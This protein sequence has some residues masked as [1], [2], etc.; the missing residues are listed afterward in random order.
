MSQF[1]DHAYDTSSDIDKIM[2]LDKKRKIFH[3][4]DIPDVTGPIQS[5]DD[6]DARIDAMDDFLYRHTTVVYNNKAVTPE[7]RDEIKIKDAME[8]GGFNVRMLMDTRTDEERQRDK[9]KERDKK[10]EEELLRRLQEIDARKKARKKG[11]DI[12]EVDVKKSEKEEAAEKK[13]KKKEKKKAKKEK[14]A[15]EAMDNITKDDEFDTAKEY[16]KY[17]EDF[18][19]F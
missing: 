1:G 3:D 6:L 18:T 16:Q 17:M 13:R 7:R 8:N 5:L 12:V 11:K 2:K 9:E 4:D 10:K 15:R 14:K 19:S